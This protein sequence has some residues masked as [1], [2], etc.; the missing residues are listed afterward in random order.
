MPE[1]MEALE[2]RAF[3]MIEECNALATKHRDNRVRDQKEMQEAQK[4]LQEARKV[5]AAARAAPT[6]GPG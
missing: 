2:A 4:R 6:A 1:T 5:I 3:R